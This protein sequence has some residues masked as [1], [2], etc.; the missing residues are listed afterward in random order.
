MN[1]ISRKPAVR[2][3]FFLRLP[4]TFQGRGILFRQSRDP[5][6]SGLTSIPR[7][8]CIYVYLLYVFIYLLY[9]S[10]FIILKLL[11]TQYP[12]KTIGHWRNWDGL[13]TT[14]R[15]IWCG[16][17]RISIGANHTTAILCSWVSLSS[18]IIV[19]W[20]MLMLCI[21]LRCI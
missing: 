8:P 4:F 11:E 15:I 10:I 18:S 7:T 17:C 12:W 9:L 21:F 1:G 5:P 6:H 13:T 16:T 19:V 20:L 14:T 3:R 2:N